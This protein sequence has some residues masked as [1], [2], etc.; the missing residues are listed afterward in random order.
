MIPCSSSAGG[1]QRRGGWH[2]VAALL[3]LAC[4]IQL[5]APAGAQAIDAAPS[6][7]L[8]RYEPTAAGSPLFLVDRPWYAPLRWAAIGLSLGYAHNPLR[9]DATQTPLASP[10]TA[11]VADALVG[12]L[13]VAGSPERWLQLRGTLPVALLERGTPDGATG[14]TPL[15][16]VSIADPR[17]GA[18][19]ALYRR[20]EH[21]P[22]SLHLGADAWLPTGNAQ[23]HQ[24][25]AQARLLPRL[26]LAGTLRQ[27]WRWTVETAF[28]YRGNA[29][30]GAP[31]RS[32]V[33]GSEVQLG[34]AIAHTRFDDR[35]HISLEARAAAR[36]TQIQATT[37]DLLRLQLLL[38]AQGRFWQQL[39][40][41]AAI[42]S[43][44]GTPGSPDLRLLLRVAWAPRLDSDRDGIPDVDDAC[45]HIRGSRH[46]DPA[47][48]GCPQGDA[49]DTVVTVDTSAPAGGPD[50][51]GDG[52]PDDRDR[53]PYEPET[54]NGIRD[55][56]GCPED[57][58]ALRAARAT[59][60]PKPGP[61]TTSTATAAPVNTVAPHVV[62]KP[63]TSDAS[64]GAGVAAALP[65]RPPIDSDRDGIPDDEDR[66][67][68]SPEDRDGF[69][70][71]DGCPDLDN[72]DDGIPDTRD[73]CPLEAETQNGYE[74][75]DGCPDVAPPGF[76][77][78]SRPGDT[79]LDSDGDGV[80]DIQDRCPYEP[81]TRNGIRDD[82]GCPESPAAAQAGQAMR[83][84]APA[85]ATI[86][87]AAPTSLPSPAPAAT[88]SPSTAGA[89]FPIADSDGDGISDEDDRCPLSPEDRDGFEDDDGCP[90]LD[91]DDDGIPDVKDRCPLDA[92]TENGFEDDDGCPDKMPAT[93]QVTLAGNRL[94]LQ[95]PVQFRRA[96]ADID[97][98]SY[99]LLREVAARLRGKADARVEI[100]GHTDPGG[101]AERNQQ[102]SQQRAEAVREFLIREGIAAHRL[103]ARGY[104]ATHPRFDNNS[105]RGRMQNRRV[106]FV[107]L[108]ERP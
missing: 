56:D 67:P 41:G 71:D 83:F 33:A 95:E 28:L 8:D 46:S 91:N 10:A 60:F 74:D 103:V 69:E 98:K 43:D 31:G 77:A 54:R 68:V 96:H 29:T 30:L 79:R 12:S 20:A 14:V 64:A 76:V 23:T 104:G 7:R 70:D 61:T 11:V 80:P 2:S 78:P 88:R 92:E 3:L 39:Q 86:A 27:S 48:S 93:A 107:I 19:F 44:L 37:G 62:P 66:C 16:Q 51:D 100:Q 59:P 106:D 24:G 47:A 97:P 22:F 34:L 75:G 25:D 90:D 50:A 58:R 1:R 65:V 35:L 81:E 17:L 84:V 57:P 18:M 99:P 101:D 49:L 5:P 53:C 63:P 36:V 32:I 89:P 85:P 94:E 40:A 72:D 6:F 4:A 38:G 42:G 9:F 15:N 45:P 82:D 55:D 73:R 21:D 102:I 13:D 105:S 52:I 108:G 26:V 87:P